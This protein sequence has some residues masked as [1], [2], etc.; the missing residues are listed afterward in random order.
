MGIVTLA[1]AQDTRTC[2]SIQ[3]C[4][5]RNNWSPRDKRLLPGGVLHSIRAGGLK[6]GRVKATSEEANAKVQGKRREKGGEGSCLGLTQR[7]EVRW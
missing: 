4:G 7:Q 2:L 1:R 3:T 5:L 6:D